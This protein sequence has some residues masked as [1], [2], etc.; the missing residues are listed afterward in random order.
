MVPAGALRVSRR[1]M[2]RFVRPDDA[3]LLYDQI[4]S[5][6]ATAE[7]AVFSRCYDPQYGCIQ[8]ETL[9]F[10]KEWYYHPGA[11]VSLLTDA[12]RV[13]ATLEYLTECQLGCAGTFPHNCYHPEPICGRRQQFMCGRCNNHCE[14]KLY[15]DGV[16]HE[17]P[18]RQFDVR[19]G[20]HEVLLMELAESVPRQERRLELVMPWGAEVH[21][22]GFRLSANTAPEL[23]KP[24][25]R[26][27]T[28][29]AYGDSIVQGFCAGTPFPEA[30]GRLNGW[31]ALNLGIGGMQISPQHGVSLGRLDADLLL[32][33]IGTNDWWKSCDVKNGIAETIDGVRSEKLNLPIVVTTMLVRGDEPNKSPHKCGIILEDFR[34]Q[35]RDEVAARRNAG[36]LKLY[37]VEGKPL[38]SLSR[39]GDGLHPGSTAAMEELAANLNAQMG[40]SAVQYAAECD[41][42]AMTLRVHLRGLTPNR[43]VKLRWGTDLENHELAAPCETRSVMVGGSGGEQSATADASGTAS[44]SVRVEKG[45]AATIFQAIDLSTCT[46]SRVGRAND[47]S[48][49]LAGAAAENFVRSP[50]PPM[51]PP[52]LLPC[53]IPP[54]PTLSEPSPPPPPPIPPPPQDP[55]APLPPR[56]SPPPPPV[57][58]PPH[59]TPSMPP[60]LEGS[61]EDFAYLAIG[62]L[63]PALLLWAASRWRSS[64]RRTPSS[65]SRRKYDSIPTGGKQRKR[66]KK[67]DTSSGCE[68][69]S[70][71]AVV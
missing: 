9:G 19:A 14:P 2:S 36:D 7:R 66:K 8:P 54:P 60:P 58:S 69:A 70:S 49:S 17:L 67:C 26:G 51:P 45:C 27:F 25:G 11:R 15:V 31:E 24:T 20:E 47:A 6:T 33:A 42:Q 29:V 22:R 28:F 35:I 21:F 46:V 23:R 65:P 5:L 62:F 50:P 3:A 56:P 13:H 53:P 34:Q 4:Y 1:D 55:A 71:R 12:K 30:L 39:L 48:S 52:P 41:T 10:G 37:L 44:I 61:I 18:E 63:G 38:L 16:L 57:P 64:G 40:F 43:E 32:I 59:P 68:P